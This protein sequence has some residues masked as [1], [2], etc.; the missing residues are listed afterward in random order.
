MPER[1]IE[2]FHQ[3]GAWYIRADGEKGAIGP[4]TSKAEALEAGRDEPRHERHDRHS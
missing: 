1:E 2:T 3:D 4:F